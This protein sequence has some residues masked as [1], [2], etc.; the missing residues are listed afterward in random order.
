VE[1][2]VYFVKLDPVVRENRLSV[3]SF[4]P[5]SVEWG[6]DHGARGRIKGLVSG[7]YK[8]SIVKPDDK[9]FLATDQDAW[10]LISDPSQC[11]TNSNSFKEALALT[12]QWS[13][14]VHSD[15]VR[16]FLRGSLDFIANH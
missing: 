12:Q 1:K 5:V 10:V 16:S 11:A 13:E 14:Q 9:G 4:S 6:P 8:L 3:K 15:V 7:L 2:G